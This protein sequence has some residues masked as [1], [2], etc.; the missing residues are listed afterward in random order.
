MEVEPV[1]VAVRR[2]ARGP[3]APGT[4]RSRP[5]QARPEPRRRP[6]PESMDPVVRRERIAL[7]C[8][9]QVPRLVPAADA[10][11]LGDDAFGVPAHR[12]IHDAIR[13]AG[14]IAQA[15]TLEPAAWVERVRQHCAE[16]V[17][18]LLTRLSVAPLPQD[19]GDRLEWLGTSSVLGIA[20]LELIRQIG[21]MRSR[22]QRQDANH[23][24]QA[25]ADLVGAE[26]RLR[27]IRERAAT[28]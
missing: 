13:A 26:Q 15:V 2:A 21:Q 3:Q 12:A 8:M 23:V 11:A 16:P 5:E 18:P 4:G 22:L 24:L 10:D 17:L 27:A 1:V 25:L 7:G 6:E 14:G 9:L 19:Q 28:A 20:E